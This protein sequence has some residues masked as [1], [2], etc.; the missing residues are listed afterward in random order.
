M[1]G[2]LLLLA[3]GSF[4]HRRLIIVIKWRAMPSS[5]DGLRGDGGGGGCH[6]ELG[7]CGGAYFGDKTTLGSS[8]CYRGATPVALKGE[9]GEKVHYA[10]HCCATLGVV[11][12]QYE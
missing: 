9:K 4:P 11:E 1:M 6:G 12:R 10:V 5:R 8:C 2:P 7:C 3:S